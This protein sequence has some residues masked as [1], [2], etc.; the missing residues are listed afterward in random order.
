MK[1]VQKWNFA[2]SK[3]CITLSR[4]DSMWWQ[5]GHGPRAPC[6]SSNLRIQIKNKIC[7]NILMLSKKYL[8]YVE[9]TWQIFHTCNKI[10][11]LNMFVCDYLVDLL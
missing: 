8:K 5:S 10:Y 11:N 4:G 2:T 9:N 7:D 3:K 1:K 6:C